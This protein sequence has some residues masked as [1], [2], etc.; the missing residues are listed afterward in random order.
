MTDSKKASDQN[1]DKVYSTKT[2]STATDLTGAT[3]KM[4]TATDGETDAA[5]PISDQVDESAIRK[6]AK[7]DQDKK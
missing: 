7:D 4:T 5:A 1:D 3:K 6:A 2:G